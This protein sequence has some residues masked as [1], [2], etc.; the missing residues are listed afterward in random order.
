MDDDDCDDCWIS[1]GDFDSTCKNLG[2]S[3]SSMTK[4]M[5]QFK[6][7]IDEYKRYEIELKDNKLSEVVKNL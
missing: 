2:H 7:E 6:R 4:L 5:K 1:T 3:K